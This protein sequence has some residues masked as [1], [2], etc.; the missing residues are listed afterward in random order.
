MVV[1]FAVRLI[2]VHI[3]LL[4]WER[5]SAGPA[6]ETL[7][8]PLAF[9][10]AVQCTD[11]ILL[12]IQSASLALG[13]EQLSVVLGTVDPTVLLQMTTDTRGMR[14]SDGFQTMVAAQMV[15]VPGLIQCI[16]DLLSRQNRVLTTGANLELTGR[17]LDFERDH[18]DKVR[19][20]QDPALVLVGLGCNGNGFTA[21]S[22]VEAIRVV[23]AISKLDRVNQ[24]RGVNVLFAVL[25]ALNST[26]A[27]VRGA[28]ACRCLS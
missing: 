3:K 23:A 26:T 14:L 17:A 20:T 12:H 9:Q 18:L 21:V 5:L 2:L 22:T 24:F 8:V 6:F 19:L 13:H 4:V 7:G 11:S 15:L 1:A 10:F 16:Y 25:A 27:T 28:T